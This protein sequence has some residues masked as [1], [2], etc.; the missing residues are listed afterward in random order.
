MIEAAE[1]FVDVQ[2]DEEGEF[3]SAPTQISFFDIAWT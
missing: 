3:S 2:L 1:Q